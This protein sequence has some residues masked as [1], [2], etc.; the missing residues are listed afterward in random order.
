[1]HSKE[2]VNLGRWS[3]ESINSLLAAAR[4]MNPG[5]RICSISEAFLGTPY[6]ETTLIGD[7]Q[8]EERLVVNL[9]E[10]DCFTFLDYV[11]AMRRSHTFHEF[12]QNVKQVR[13]RSGLVA[14][15]RRNHFFTD[16]IVRNRS[17]L[18]DVT[19]QI[20]LG[21]VQTVKKHLNEKADGTAFVP[22]I[23]PIERGITYLPAGA[24][25]EALSRL[26]TGDYLG[27]YSPAQ[28]LDVSHTGIAI[29]VQGGFV[30]RHASSQEN[31]RRVVDQGLMEYLNNKPG[32]IV[33][34]PH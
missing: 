10:I 8:T 5:H 18:T 14:F 30:L 26:Q 7:E 20:G 23:P 2:T 33:L 13:Y 19:W 24:L 4:P 25:C 34:R 16:W 17:H 12:V 27:V 1:M 29:E 22:G 15:T 21:A 32:I 6:K 31:V 3:E 11:E 9:A 28:G